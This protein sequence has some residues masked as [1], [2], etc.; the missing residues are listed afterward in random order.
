MFTVHKSHYGWTARCVS[1][2]HVQAITKE[3]AS[4]DREIECEECG[5]RDYVD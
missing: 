2:G 3:Q 4:G 1:C 5:E